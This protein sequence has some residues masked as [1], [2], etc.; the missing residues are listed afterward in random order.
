MKLLDIHEARHSLFS[1]IDDMET[2]SSDLV[3]ILATITDYLRREDPEFDSIEKI[4]YRVHLD[5][6]SW[7]NGVIM[8]WDFDDPH[9][10]QYHVFSFN[11]GDTDTY[12]LGKNMELSNGNIQYSS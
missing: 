4:G 9:D 6:C 7:S 10:D 2:P 11:E 12:R 3:E 1:Y 8:G 5:G